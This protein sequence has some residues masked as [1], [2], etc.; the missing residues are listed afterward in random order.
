MNNEQFGYDRTKRFF[1]GGG[2]RGVLR[3]DREKGNRREERAERRGRG[4]RTQ[5]G[6]RTKR[7]RRAGERVYRQKRDGTQNPWWNQLRQSPGR[8]TRA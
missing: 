6:E 8:Q 3:R 7:K 4:K 5:E 1:P 2:G